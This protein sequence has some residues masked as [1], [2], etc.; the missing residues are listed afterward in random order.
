[1]SSS[2]FGRYTVFVG[3][4]GCRARVE[5]EAHTSDKCS[6]TELCQPAQVA[7]YFCLFWFSL[8]EMMERL[9]SCVAQVNLYIAKNECKLLILLFPV[10][11][12]WYTP[13]D[14]RNL[15]LESR[16]YRGQGLGR[17]GSKEPFLRTLSISFTVALPTSSPQSILGEPVSHIGEGDCHDWLGPTRIYSLSTLPPPHQ[18]WIPLTRKNRVK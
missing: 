12:G 7:C 8:F 6:K 2:Q 10:L 4:R 3:V 18:I 16:K 9:G 15:D 13:S 5:L 17:S 14:V 1:M 11:Q